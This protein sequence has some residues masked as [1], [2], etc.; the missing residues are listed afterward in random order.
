MRAVVQRVKKASVR[1]DGTVT[2]AIEKGLLVFAGIER[3]DDARDLE[4]VSARVRGLRVFEDAAGKMNLDV[5][6]A[7][8]E[9]LV[10]SQFTLLGDCTKGRRPSFERA[11]T[12]E[13][14]V[15]LYEAL[16]KNLAD[17]GVAVKQGRFQ[18]HMEIESTND[19]PVTI[20]L[21]SRKLF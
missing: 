14:A 10:V 2:G 1:V 7:G 11:E 3:G 15:A 5:K 19:G 21:D 16:I 9:L 17:S 18:A 12:P 8:G 20:I 4:Y 13:K 6:D